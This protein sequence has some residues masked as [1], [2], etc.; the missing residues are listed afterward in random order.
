MNRQPISI[1]LEFHELNK[2]IQSGYIHRLGPGEFPIKP[3]NKLIKGIIAPF[4]DFDDSS[5]AQAW[6]YKELAETEMPETYIIIGS[7][8][9]G[10][11]TYLFSD[12][13]TPFG[14]VKVDTD[15]G[16]KIVKQ[17]PQLK[18]D[19]KQFNEDKSIETQLPLLQFAK[20]DYLD[21]IKFLPI[22]VG[23]E[24]YEK[25][26]DFA[27]TLTTIANKITIICSANFTK[28]GREFGYIP[29]VH[30]IK[31]NLHNIDK[32]LI[33][34]IINLNSKEFINNSKLLP[35]KN[36]VLLTIEIM[37]SIGT[38]SGSLLN[39]YTSGELTNN[40]EKSIGMSAIV[41]R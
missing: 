12:W 24:E 31:E 37:K 36:A 21:K 5:P 40:Y 27:D 19:V 20:R 9:E 23:N 39:Y 14:T 29:F 4:Y 18:N 11:N 6:S 1:N 28:Y 32:K 15:L 41:F 33:D 16:K 22:L 34:S 10:F 13:E 38:R 35:D 8:K 25:I 26:F 7:C 17:Y 30:G 2:K 3:K